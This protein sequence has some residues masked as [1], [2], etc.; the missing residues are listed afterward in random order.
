MNFLDF[1]KEDVD[2]ESYPAG[3]AIFRENDRGDTMFIIKG[4]EVEV[5]VNGVY[6]RTLGPGEVLGEMALI[7]DSP[8]SAD[9]IAKTDCVLI[10]VDERRFLFLVHEQPMFAMHMMRVMA[11][12]LRDQPG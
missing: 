8:R 5:Q 11:E 7:D 4:G 1:F 12:R 2:A 6:I 10:P 9:A 3:T